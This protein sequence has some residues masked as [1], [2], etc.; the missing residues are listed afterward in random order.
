MAFFVLVSSVCL[1][2]RLRLGFRF[3]LWC[4]WVFGFLPGVAAVV[5]LCA[6]WGVLLS[7]LWGSFLSVSCG[8]GLCFV[9]SSLLPLALWSAFGACFVP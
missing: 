6:W 9:V 3:V 2:C 8:P 7:S 4:L 5:S 1:W